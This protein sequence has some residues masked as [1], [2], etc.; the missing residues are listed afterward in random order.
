MDKKN[1]SSKTA[2]KGLINGFIAYGILILFLFF[3][4]IVLVS[5][6]I[7]SCKEYIDYELLKYTLPA[8]GAFLL[9]FLIRAICRL[10]T[11][12]LFKKCQIDKD[13]IEEVSTKMNLFYIGFVILS[14]IAIVVS[15]IARFKNE[16][17]D[18]KIVSDSYYSEYSEDFADYLTLELL[19]DFQVK[20]TNTIIAY[21]I[22]EIGLLL[23]IFSLI[24]NQKNLIE[25]YNI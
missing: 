13:K 2:V 11:Y 15:L 19:S 17:T 21:T 1:I 4:L 16:K 25:K 23:G 22:I 3:I 9:F 14:I 5:W 12:D 6:A 10:S 18:I 20:R 8:L 7:N 24:P